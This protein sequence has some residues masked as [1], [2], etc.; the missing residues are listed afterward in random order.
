MKFLNL[1]FS[2]CLL[3]PT[4]ILN[5]HRLVRRG[6]NGFDTE[7]IPLSF[8]Y[9][10][11]TKECFVVVYKERKVVEELSDTNDITIKACH[12][13]KNLLHWM[14]SDVDI[15]EVIQFPQNNVIR[16]FYYCLLINHWF[17]GVFLFHL[18]CSLVSP[19]FQHWYAWR[20]DL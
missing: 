9:I 6:W 3:V 15:W 10:L 14:Q 16:I 19:L 8:S 17:C 5:C 13:Q 20:I 2:L 12:I 1:S 7:I 4:V 11:W 18:V